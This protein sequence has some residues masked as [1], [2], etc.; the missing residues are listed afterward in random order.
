MSL[1]II[2]TPIGNLG[3]ITY[4]AVQTLSEVDLILAEDT[5]KSRILLNHYDINTPMQSYHMHNE[6]QSTDHWITELRN[7]RNI[8]LISD[9]GTPG[10][11]DPGYLL[12]TAAID[13]DIPLEIL[14]GPTAVVPALLYSGLHLHEFT[15]WGFVPAK[16]GK[17][18]FLEKWANC[19][20]TS[21][22]YESPHK[23]LKTLEKLGDYIETERKISVSREL[24]KKFEETIRG[25][26]AEVFSH[27][28]NTQVKGEFVICLEGTEAY[29][30]RIKK[31]N[32]PK[33]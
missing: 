14:P 24:T 26:F 33:N 13:H 19:S 21:A 20:H 6:N 8:A 30:K 31:L 4:R 11:S 29:I 32:E 16:K 9:A 22:V 27:F 23:L 28:Q 7:G 17:Q 3:D 10:V 1:S 15:F 25:T 12:I 18:S 5:R 2:A